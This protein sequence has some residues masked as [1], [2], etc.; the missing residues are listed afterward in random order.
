M[1]KNIINKIIIFF[2]F[3]LFDFEILNYGISKI[4]KS[5][6]T[7]KYI[8]YLRRQKN[9]NRFLYWCKNIF[10]NCL[11]FQCISYRL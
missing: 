11:N 6:Y 3:F 1:V 5:L 10:D 2:C 9:E 8:G 7:D 4:P